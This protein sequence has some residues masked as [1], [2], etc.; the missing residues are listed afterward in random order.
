M[1]DHT[2]SSL[3][4][5]HPLIR[6]WF[7][8]KFGSPTE[9][10][11]QGWPYILAKKAT[12]ISAPTGSGKTFTAFL[13]CI[14]KLFRD[15]L[16]N[17][18]EDKTQVLYISPLK[19]LNNDIQKN[20]IEPLNE[21]IQ[22]AESQGY[23]PQRIRIAV[24][25]GDTLAKD[26]QN[27]LKKP[28]HI[29]I[30]T[31]ESFFILLTAEKSRALLHDVKTVIVDEI[32]ALANNKRG[33]HLCLSLERL[34]LLTPDSFIRIGLSATQKPLDEVGHLLVG[35]GRPLPIIIHIEYAKDFDLAVLVP[36][37]ELSA[38]ASNEMWD[39]IYDRLAELISKH[40]STLI[41]VNTRRL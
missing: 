37:S 20:L 21:I 27:M 26:R 13:I 17:K 30:T 4:W 40:R 14:D 23:S 1:S 7:I 31:P 5:A 32:H 28:P 34:E 16:N 2:L 10:Q 9:P 15:A 35:N 25:T 41:F 22:L 36:K 33:T 38:V 29:L 12:L 11:Q 24:R 6:E 3:N 18:L 19:A 8:N 39:E